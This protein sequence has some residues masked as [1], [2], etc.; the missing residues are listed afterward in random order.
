MFESIKKALIN[1]DDTTTDNQK[2]EPVKET[3]KTKF[4]IGQTTP[5]QTTQPEVSTNWFGKSTA[6]EQV[7]QPVSTQAS[8]EHI[9]K[10]LDAYQQGLISLKQA[11]YDFQNFYDALS[12]EDKKN[13]SVYQMAVR[14][15]S[16]MDKS[17][18]KDKLIQSA[19]YYIGKIKE[20]YSAYVASGNGKKQAVLNQKADENRNLTSELEML[21]GQAQAIQTQI[22]DRRNKIASIDNKYAGQLSEIDSKL[23]ANDIAK[24]QVVGSLEFVKQGIINNVK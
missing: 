19:D 20:N 4:P 14:F 5:T 10:A 15:A 12:E 24:D 23:I 13:P 9:N 18:S 11:G 16:S 21:E 2:Q 3:G 1:S 6:V 17:V 22:A 8:P 7:V